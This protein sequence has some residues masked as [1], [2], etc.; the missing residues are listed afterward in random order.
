MVHVS[1]DKK[2]SVHLVNLVQIMYDY[3]C[4]YVCMSRPIQ[5]MAAAN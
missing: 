3:V 2:E 4:M 1:V 5:N